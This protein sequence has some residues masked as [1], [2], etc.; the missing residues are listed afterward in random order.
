M[1]YDPFKVE[2]VT[3]EKVTIA[4]EIITNVLVVYY[5]AGVL[6]IAAALYVNLAHQ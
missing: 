1:H 5:F 2:V 3:Q 4:Q 6:S